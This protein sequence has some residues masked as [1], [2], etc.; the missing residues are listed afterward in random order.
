[1]NNDEPRHGISIGGVRRLLNS[2][3]DAILYFSNKPV[4]LTDS[5]GVV[6]I[7]ELPI[8]A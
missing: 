1:M 6:G 7:N 5:P 8:S 3:K 2:A 4:S